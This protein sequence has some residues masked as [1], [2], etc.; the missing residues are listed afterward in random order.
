MASLGNR[1]SASH[2]A[3]IS[4]ELTREWKKMAVI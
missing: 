2:I 3:I 4:R 1:N